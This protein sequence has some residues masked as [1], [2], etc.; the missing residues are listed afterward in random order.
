MKNDALIKETENENLKVD[1]KNLM[2]ENF[3]L[4]DE[5]K[6]LNEI[7]MS[8]ISKLKKHEVQRELMSKQFNLDSEKK[9]SIPK[10]KNRFKNNFAMLVILY[11]L[12]FFS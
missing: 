7:N 11:I 6:K 9:N 12:I 3:K 8:L 1:L 2:D 10:N 4:Q 5:I